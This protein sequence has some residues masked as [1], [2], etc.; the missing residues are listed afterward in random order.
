LFYSHANQIKTG[1]GGS[2][3]H[4]GGE[5]LSARRSIK[6]DTSPPVVVSV[7]SPNNAGVYGEGDVLEI[8]VIFDK[9]VSVGVYD[10]AYDE[11][12]D[13]VTHDEITVE[14]ETRRGVPYLLL[15]VGRL[16]DSIRHAQLMWH[17]PAETEGEYTYLHKAYFSKVNG[18]TVTFRYVVQD[19]DYSLRLDYLDQ[20]ALKLNGGWIRRTSTT[21]TT[22]VDVLLPPPG[23]VNSLGGNKLFMIYPMPARVVNVVPVGGSQSLGAF[24]VIKIRVQFGWGLLAGWRGPDFTTPL[25]ELTN[26]YGVPVTLSPDAKPV[27]ELQLDVVPMAVVWSITNGSSFAV[28]EEGSGIENS[29][30]LGVKFR[31]T[32]QGYSQVIILQNAS[33]NYIAFTPEWSGVNVQSGYPAANVTTLDVR[34]ATYSG[35]NNTDTLI[36]QYMTLPGDRT[37]LLDYTSTNALIMSPNS[38]LL[39]LS[40]RPSTP[41]NTTL[42]AP[43]TCS[44]NKQ[45]GCSLSSP[46]ADDSAV[47]VEGRS[48]SEFRPKVVSLSTSKRGDLS[49]FGVGEPIEVVVSFNK[50]VAVSSNGSAPALRL[51]PGGFATYAYGSG[52]ANLTFFYVVGEGD[53]APL[54]ESYSDGYASS[55]DP[56]DSRITPLDI[57]FLGHEVGWIRRDSNSPLTP[58]L[59][60]P[61]HGGVG[62]LGYSQ[63]MREDRIVVCT[64]CPKVKKVVAVDLPDSGILGAGHVLVLEVRFSS[65]VVVNTTHGTPYIELRLSGDYVVDALYNNGSGT[66]HLYFKYTVQEGDPYTDPVVVHERSDDLTLTTSIMRGGGDIVSGETGHRAVLTLSRIGR[67]RALR[68]LSLDMTVAHSRPGV[69]N[70]FSPDPALTFRRQNVVISTRPAFVHTV[71]TEEP[72]NYVAVYK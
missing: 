64:S 60:L 22:N 59:L 47:D 21:P 23:G 37:A 7:T 2:Y 13:G 6:I 50:P 33:S 40:T 66:N 44:P 41:V 45:Y 49:P 12:V 8:E 53:A 30:A 29:W 57:Y 56:A 16:S 34:N 70:P 63:R 32:V 15:V 42:V 51:S 69:E 65:Y 18:N 17:P 39:R 46:D 26:R 5:S 52:T 1:F 4:H 58:A 38:T 3:R 10:W 31:I 25:R 9:P 55:F 11:V 27:L 14:H 43:S 48:Q 62:S 67:E 19:L 68:T 61:S 54:L 28:L 24:E 20:A 72:D 35:G 71:E 36:F